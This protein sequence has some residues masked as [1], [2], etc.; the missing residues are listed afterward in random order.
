M[1]TC[2]LTFSISFNFGDFYGINF[3]MNNYILFSVKV[4]VIIRDAFTD[5]TN[6][7]KGKYSSG[8]E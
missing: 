6:I 8:N 4:T 5:K 2:F 3:I 7:L 1:I